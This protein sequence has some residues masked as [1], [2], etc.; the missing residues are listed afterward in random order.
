MTP[1]TGSR[2]LSYDSETKRNNNKEIAYKHI[3]NAYMKKRKKIVK[4][5]KKKSNNNRKRS[6]EKRKEKRAL[7]DGSFS[8][9]FTREILG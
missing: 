8:G 3:G 1:G 5:Q 9:G 6:R 2:T 4:R 7:G